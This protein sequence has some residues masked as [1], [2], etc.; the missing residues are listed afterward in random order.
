MIIV[1]IIYIDGT[2]DIKCCND[3]CE[4]CLD[5]VESIKIIREE[6]AA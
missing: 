6:K 3:L 5:G 4:L 1:R 2:N